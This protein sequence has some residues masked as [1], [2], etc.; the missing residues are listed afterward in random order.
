MF[1][2]LK[3]GKIHHQIK[4]IT[5]K[6]VFFSSSFRPNVRLHRAKTEAH[7]CLTTNTT[8]LNAAVNKVSSENIVKSVIVDPSIGTK[9]KLTR[10]LTGA[11]AMNVRT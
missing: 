4:Q 8:P 11:V 10:S 6:N 7:V 9:K 5:E 3:R 2:H 1:G